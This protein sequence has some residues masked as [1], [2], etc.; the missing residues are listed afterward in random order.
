MTEFDEHDNLIGLRFNICD[1]VSQILME[2]QAAQKSIDFVT[3]FDC[4]IADGFRSEEE[5]T[6]SQGVMIN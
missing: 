6:V 2:S 3:L 5:K 1:G 4:D